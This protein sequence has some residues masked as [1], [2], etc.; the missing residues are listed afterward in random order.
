M[1]V[2]RHQ[3]QAA[4]WEFLDAARAGRGGSL[5]LRG[6]AGIGKT[7]LLTRAVA[8]ANGMVVAHRAGTESE[9]GLPYA[10]LFDLTTGALAPWLGHLVPEQRGVLDSA[11]ALG[12]PKPGDRFAVAVALLRLLAAVSSETPVLVALDDLQW[13]DAESREAIAF[14]A[15]RL[16]AESVAVLLAVLEPEGA[17]L[18]PDF[19]ALVIGP[20]TETDSA[21]LLYRHA[22]E[23]APD[24]A[25]AILR[26]SGGNPLALGQLPQL[27][28]D[29]GPEGDVPLDLSPLLVGERLKRAYAARL[30]GLSAATRLLLVVVAASR[31]GDS[32]VV[33]EVARRLGHKFD[34]LSP[35]E[36]AG[37]VRLGSDRVV[38]RHELARSAVYHGADEA[39]LRRA[40][41]ALAESVEGDWR[42]E[43]RAWHL[44]RAARGVDETAAAALTETAARSAQRGGFHAAGEAMRRAAELTPPGEERAWRAVAAAQAACRAA[45]WDGA[46]RALEETDLA[47]AEPPVRAAAAAVLAHLAG[48]GRGDLTEA[49]RELA[50]AAEGIAGVDRERAARLLVGAW[51]LG[52]L[53]GESPSDLAAVAARADQLAEPSP[54]GDVVS[55]RL[56]LLAIRGMDGDAA[57]ADDLVDGLQRVRVSSA[58]L[59]ELAPLVC[60]L[61]YVALDCER[62]DEARAA[63][64]AFVERARSEAAVS[65]LPGPLTV[66]SSCAFATGDWTT[67]YVAAAESARL[68]SD[69][70][71]TT[72]ATRAE[73]G[74]AVVEA[75]LGREASC[76]ESIERAGATDRSLGSAPVDAQRSFALGLLRAG[77]G[78]WDTAVRHLD[79]IAA[80][81]QIRP[82][83]PLRWQGLYLEALARTGQR[84][85]ARNFLGRWEDERGWCKGR[86]RCVVTERILMLLGDEPKEPREDVGPA[87][88]DE[89][90][91]VFEHACL[92][93]CRGERLL[94][95]GREAEADAALRGARAAF[96]RLGAT[97]WAK[98]AAALL[99]TVGPTAP[100]RASVTTNPAGVQDL[101]A[102]QLEVAAAVAGGTSPAEAAAA[103][104]LGRPTVE[105]VLDEALTALELTS[106]DELPAS[107]G[108]GITV[109]LPRPE[110]AVAAEPAPALACTL[111]R[112][113]SVTVGS[114]KVRLPGLAGRLVA[115]VALQPGAIAIDE[116]IESLWPEVEPE[117]GRVRLRKVLWRIRGQ[118]AGLI[119]RIGDEGLALG[120]NVEVDVARFRRLAGEAHAA[121][122][123]DQRADAAR[124]AVAS[125]SGELLPELPYEEWAREPR[126]RLRAQFVALLDILAADAAA[127]EDYA[128]AAA[129]LDQAIS[130]DPYEEGRYLRC[131]E[132]LDGLGRRGPAVL[133]LERARRSMAELGLGLS[134]AGEALSGRLR[135]ES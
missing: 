86:W 113:F 91:L 63:I 96:E 51:S 16:R 58:P 125:Y 77:Q 97:G 24:V 79:A 87:R 92:D 53:F 64:V 21:T 12:P 4:L 127:R 15:R 40:H 50:V 132:L 18:L 90:G 13:V 131:A 104:F 60:T 89:L 34:D 27:I 128:Q 109:G 20:L 103:L 74:R 32:T 37:L 133:Q 25:D 105:R 42:V 55:G 19:P 112:R 98:Q 30:G 94:G 10:T 17:A 88:R 81:G 52:V 72:I 46:R 29:Q 33:A 82:S 49:Q 47:P 61:G 126:E 35:A 70:G 84:D 130:H 117:L 36:R 129:F 115:L 120:A 124:A 11:L 122:S 38:F 26:V 114:R 118:H 102:D 7:A 101:P 116:V 108:Q 65:A 85:L 83:G 9:A 135:P 69:T 110:P 28:G 59:A 62:F 134:A 107:F 5:I 45:D 73:L 14:A 2:G 41:L 76:G 8:A 44:A 57:A 22:P 66:L 23:A 1:L 93:L 80:A 68:A 123:P 31:D 56:P 119:N 39:V 54:T 75:V 67:A 71:Q 95:L 100:G 3:E 6:E 78:D 43:R 121:G 99:L 106:P 48:A 111:L